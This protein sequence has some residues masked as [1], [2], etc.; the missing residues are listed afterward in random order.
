[1]LSTWTLFIAWVS[2][3]PFTTYAGDYWWPKVS[4]SLGCYGSPQ[5]CAWVSIVNFSSK[6]QNWWDTLKI[7]RIV[8]RS[9]QQCRWLIHLAG[10]KRH[11]NSMSFS[12]ELRRT[13]C[14]HLYICSFIIYWLDYCLTHTET[15]SCDALFWPELTERRYSTAYSGRTTL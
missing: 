11:M 12:A 8:F 2:D 14:A 7:S 9:R 10:Y 1:M 15:K 3:P 5:L 6:Y 13:V 4:V